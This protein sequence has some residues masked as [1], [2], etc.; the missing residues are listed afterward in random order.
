MPLYNKYIKVGSLDRFA[1]TNS[2]DAFN[3]IDLDVVYYLKLYTGRSQTQNG[4]LLFKQ[5]KDKYTTDI[6]E[7]LEEPFLKGEVNRD[8]RFQAI[9][10]D[11]KY[12]NIDEK[13]R[14]ELMRT[15]QTTKY[16]QRNR[17]DKVGV[18]T[19]EM[20]SASMQVV[21]ERDSRYKQFSL[22]KVTCTN[23]NY[24]TFIVN[25]VKLNYNGTKFEAEGDV[26]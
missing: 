6:I 9:Y 12:R 22:P 15:N 2:I 1:F 26:D 11:A 24:G 8:I 25:G 19:K 10:F 21:K 17:F 13:Q 20:Q 14:Q 7:M 18:V 4:S 5:K 23:V 16:L 3:L